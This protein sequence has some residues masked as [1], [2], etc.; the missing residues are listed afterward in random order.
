MQILHS[1][2]LTLLVTSFG[3]IVAAV[4]ASN[5]DFQPWRD[6]LA[7]AGAW[8]GVLAVSLYGLLAMLLAVMGLIAY[9]RRRLK[10]RT[11]TWP[12]RQYHQPP[13]HQPPIHEPF[14]RR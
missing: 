1:G 9:L 3:F 13:T 7:L 10:E 12:R 14:L 11:Q 5:S 4:V 2:A 8:N 6:G